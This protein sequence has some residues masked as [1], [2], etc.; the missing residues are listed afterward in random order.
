M[1]NYTE[2]FK[3]FHKK[4]VD[5]NG[6]KT[7]RLNYDLNEESVVFDVGGYKGDW[8]ESIFNLYKCNIYIFEPV[9]SYFNQINQKFEKNDKIKV[10]NYGLG[11]NTREEFININ[12][13]SSSLYNKQEDSNG[14]KVLIKSLNEVFSELSLKN[15]DLCKLNIE[16]SE[17][18]LLNHII[19][20]NLLECFKNFQIQFH[21][22]SEIKNCKNKR[23]LILKSI[24]KTHN[25]SY[26]FPWVWE[27][28]CLK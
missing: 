10:F 25:I 15:I 13:D 2:E 1:I 11:N 27:G 21:D 5:E 18:E 17:Y 7:Y 6:D 16:G 12:N 4:W 3:I 20:N 19:K 8:S 28:F 22:I 26:S 9:K 24:T 14:N 23:D